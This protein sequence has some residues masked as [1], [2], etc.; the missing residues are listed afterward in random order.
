MVDDKDKEILFELL[1]DCRQPLSKVSKAVRFP[2][3]TVSYRIKKLEKDKVIKKYTININYPKLG[4]SR[5]SLY[6]DLMHI[7]AEEVDSYLKGITDIKE[8]SCCYMLHDISQ[9]KLYI[10]VW[11]KSISRYDEIQTKI[12]SKFRKHIKN[13]LSFQSVKSWTYFARRL[14]TKKH[15]LIDIK[16]DPENFNL[17]DS[18]WKLIN[19][20][21][22][23]SKKSVLELAKEL[24]TSANTIIRRIKFLKDNKI[25]ER[26][27]PII[28]MNKVGFKEYTFIS[29]IDPAYH[30]NI[31]ALIDYAKK[32]PRFVIVIK[33]VGYINLYYAFLAKNN[34]ELK[35]IKSKIEKILGKGVLEE[36]RIEVE[37]MIS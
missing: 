5:H 28:D 31:E 9:W 8:V 21:K 36:H 32:D 29:R 37:D 2:Q 24:K 10:S 33:A 30:K 19:K 11:T 22:K 34:D 12:V 17:K 6:L 4:Y 1:Q 15:S 14:N 16:G 25:I 23:N 26:F 35:E 18:D 27:Y 7:G 13:Y 3:Q 20:L